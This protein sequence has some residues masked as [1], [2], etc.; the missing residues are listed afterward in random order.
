MNFTPS[1]IRWWFRITGR[2]H[3]LKL[4]N[5]ILGSG[6]PGS[7]VLPTELIDQALELLLSGIGNTLSI[8]SNRQWIWPFWVERQQNPSCKDFIPTGVNVLT[9]N[10]CRRNWT[11]LGCYNSTREVMIDPVGMLTLAPFGWSLLPYL[12]VDGA[13]WAPPR[14]HKKIKQ[15]ITEH[16]PCGLVTQYDM[17]KEYEWKVTA[18]PIVKGNDEWLEWSIELINTSAVV[19]EF[20]MGVGIRP[21]NMLTMSPIHHLVYQNRSWSINGE[22]ALE[23]D[24]DPSYIRL[25]DRQNGD[26]MLSQLSTGNF[27][28]SSRSGLLSGVMEVKCSLA[29]QQQ[30]SWQGRAWIGKAPLRHSDELLKLGDG[31]RKQNAFHISWPRKFLQSS[32]DGI[33]R[34]IHVFDDV[35]YYTPGSFFYHHH[36]IR[37]SAFLM[38]ADLNLGRFQNLRAK[39]DTWMKRQNSSGMFSSQKGEW[40]SSGQVLVLVARVIKRTGDKEIL[41]LYYEKLKRAA[42]WIIKIRRSKVA[43]KGIYE[44]LLP[45]GI[46]AEH[47]GPNDHYFWDNFWSLAGL[48]SWQEISAQRWSLAEKKWWASEIESYQSDIDRAMRLAMERFGEG[49]LP[50]APT[51]RF[52][53]AAIGNLVAIHPLALFSEQCDWAQATSDNLHRQQVHQGLFFQDIIHTG[54]NCYLTL[55]LATVMM[56]QND[57][58]YLDLLK[59]VIS[60]GGS[61]WSWPEAIHPMTGGGC[62]GDGDHGW[63][64]AEVINLMRDMVVLER[65]QTLHI[66]RG[67]CEKWFE[68]GEKIQVE[69]APVDE[70]YLSYSLEKI[71]GQWKLEWNLKSLNKELNIVVWDPLAH[72]KGE[73]NFKLLEGHQGTLSWSNANELSQHTL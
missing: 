24:W 34:R 60:A 26:P 29:P 33:R 65:G 19:Q 35:D 61:T 10:L 71:Q 43:G 30:K 40:D 8:H 6:K 55:Q 64:L 67:L 5:G 44:G 73:R 53:S 50:C 4:Y 70:G 31:V 49:C 45:S 12:K 15:S 57:L 54:F 66:G 22:L 59:S 72:Q 14:M 27:Q 68:H 25:S 7:T 52:D 48:I 38:M 51:R 16:Q 11:T 20:I 63:V 41:N 1:L 21:Y 56:L 9:T 32:F 36:W 23:C 39:L 62:M 42:K 47:F 13:L 46:S 3:L 58:R 17:G 69:G 18:L 37:D 28:M 2:K